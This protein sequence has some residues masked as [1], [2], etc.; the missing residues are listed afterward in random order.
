M[1]V[2]AISSKMLKA[3]TDPELGPPL[4]RLESTLGPLGLWDED[5]DSLRVLLIAE[6]F[7]RVREAAPA[8]QHPQEDSQDFGSSG[9]GRVACTE[10]LL[11]REQGAYTGV[12]FIVL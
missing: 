1:L 5:T 8:R 9:Q 3:R 10:G 2:S 7:V 11:R 12:L 6:A 4:A